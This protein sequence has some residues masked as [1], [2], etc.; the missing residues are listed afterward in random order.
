MWNHVITRG[1]IWSGSPGVSAAW[2]HDLAGKMVQ[3]LGPVE[4][5][6]GRKPGRPMNRRFRSHFLMA[7]LMQMTWWIITSGNWHNYGTSLFFWRKTLE[8]SMAMFYVKWLIMFAL[9]ITKDV[10][11]R[12]CTIAKSSYVCFFSGTYPPQKRMRT[13]GNPILGHLQLT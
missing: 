8:L 10:G 13:G 6:K 7:D 1:Y 3:D 12:H 5:Q 9:W 11:P 4:R 2:C